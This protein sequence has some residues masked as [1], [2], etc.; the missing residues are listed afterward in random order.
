MSAPRRQEII[1]GIIGIA[2]TVI[3]SFF[4]V[5][6]YYTPAWVERFSAE[7]IEREAYRQIDEKIDSLT[8]PDGKGALS[9]MAGAL[10][11]KH[12]QE[13]ER[14]RESLRLQVHERMADAIAQIRDLDCECR[15]KWAQW[16]KEGTVARIHLLRQT[17]ESIREFIH[18]TYARVVA[19][20]KRDIRIFTASNAIMFLLLLALAGIKPLAR[21]QL[22]VPGLLL[23]VATL[24]CSFFYI[25]EQ[26]WLLTIIYNDYLG[27]TYLAYLGLVFGLLCDI[28]LNRARIT[29][30]IVNSALSAIGS[31]ASAA[32]C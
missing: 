10:Y 16:L 17:N 12:E 3:F 28:A 7:F 15:A 18:S 13:I 29:T 6:T 23:A 21:L 2:G 19:D 24:L 30:E 1:L 27:F 8:P 5:L 25:F 9:R 32:P 11:E 4:L 22:F 20:L 26:N 31:V 14:H